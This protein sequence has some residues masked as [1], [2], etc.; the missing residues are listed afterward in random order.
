MDLEEEQKPFRKEWPIDPKKRKK[1]AEKKKSENNK[2][3]NNSSKPQKTTHSNK[4]DPHVKSNNSTN[5]NSTE[6]VPDPITNTSKSQRTS[7][8]LQD[9]KDKTEPYP[10]Q[11]LLLQDEGEEHSSSSKGQHG[12]S[13]SEDQKNGN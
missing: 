2:K 4:E 5:T 3:K 12:P 7:G 13:Y 8:K 10:S 1:I 9:L 6:A 11:R